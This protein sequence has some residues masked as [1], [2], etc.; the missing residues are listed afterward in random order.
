MKTV[1]TVNNV[2]KSPQTAPEPVNKVRA[3][4]RELVEVC[5][6]PTRLLELYYWSAEPE[7]LQTLHRYISMPEQP[8]EALRA[9]LTMVEDSPDSVR[10]HVSRNGDVTLSSHVIAQLMNSR[11]VLRPNT[12]QAEASH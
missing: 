8:R 3:V 7:L 2:K 10:V 5:P 9:F 6:H 12:D 11:D 4:L 1:T